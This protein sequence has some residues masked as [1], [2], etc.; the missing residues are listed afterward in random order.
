[1]Y[2]SLSNSV[3]AGITCVFPHTFSQLKPA[4]ADVMVKSIEL[5]SRGGGFRS[6]LRHI[7]HTQVDQ[8]L[9]IGKQSTGCKVPV[10][11]LLVLFCLFHTCP[12]V[13]VGKQTEHTRQGAAL[14]FYRTFYPPSPP[15]Y[16][17]ILELGLFCGHIANIAACHIHSQKKWDPGSRSF[18]G[19]N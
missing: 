18:L 9:K 13:E 7:P 14:H 6:P 4:R 1:M 10:A 16:P 15:S 12:R 17:F 2:L 11:C 5:I 3:R 8:T 19:P